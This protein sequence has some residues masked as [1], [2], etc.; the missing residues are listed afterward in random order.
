MRRALGMNYLTEALARVRAENIANG[1]C[2][3]CGGAGVVADM[4][5]IHRDP[6]ANR[7]CR[8]CRGTGKPSISLRKAQH[9]R[10]A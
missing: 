10:K 1:L 8:T 2:P 5:K 4:G 9:R 7:R 6:H 3:D